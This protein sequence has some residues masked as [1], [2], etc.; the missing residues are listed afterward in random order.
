MATSE[1]N[2]E[3]QV[4][5]CKSCGRAYIVRKREAQCAHTDA[6][7]NYCCLCRKAFNAKCIKEKEEREKRK[8]QLKKAEDQKTFESIL[9]SWNVTKL[10]DIKVSSNSLYIIGN[11]FDLMHGV[12]SSYYAFR[13]TLGK[14]SSLRMCLESFWTP[15]DIW[16]DLENG[17]AHF[18]MNSMGSRMMVDNWLDVS[19]T[20]AEDAR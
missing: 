9:S 8:W 3:A 4:F 17:L 13:D 5:T 15:E 16:A 1:I 12:K 10:N 2:N 14:H 19:D 18:N 6:Y 20:Y 7:L 11:G